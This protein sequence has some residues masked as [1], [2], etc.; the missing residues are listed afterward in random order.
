MKS[1][2]R[3]V[4]GIDGCGYRITIH[5]KDVM[6]SEVYSGIDQLNIKATHSLGEEVSGTFKHVDSLSGKIGLI[7]QLARKMAPHY[8]ERIDPVRIELKNCIRP[9]GT[10]SYMRAIDQANAA[11]RNMHS[12]VEYLRKRVAELEDKNKQLYIQQD[13]HVEA[14]NEYRDNHFK[15]TELTALVR[16]YPVNANPSAS[17]YHVREALHKMF[18][19]QHAVEL[20]AE[21]VKMHEELKGIYKDRVLVLEKQVEQMNEKVLMWD[22]ICKRVGLCPQRVGLR[23]ISSSGMAKTL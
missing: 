23:S 21:R 10:A 22:E 12:E 3:F 11:S 16:N 13:Q 18:R 14:L 8:G 9:G 20:H 7:K 1:S 19:N 6:F 2:H 17:V 15:W 4:F 5:S